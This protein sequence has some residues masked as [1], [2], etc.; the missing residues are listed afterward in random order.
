MELLQTNRLEAAKDAFYQRG[1]SIINLEHGSK[2]PVVV[3][4]TALDMLTLGVSALTAIAMAP[5]GSTPNWGVRCGLAPGCASP[6]FVLDLDTYKIKDDSQRETVEKLKALQTLLVETPTGGYHVYFQFDER[7]KTLALEKSIELFGYMDIRSTGT[8]VVGWSSVLSNAGV[9]QAYAKKGVVLKHEDYQ[10]VNSRSPMIMPD[11][12]YNMIH[13]NLPKKQVHVGHEEGMAGDADGKPT[14]YNVLRDVVMGL[15]KERSVEYDDWLTVVIS[16]VNVSM[17]NG[18]RSKGLRLCHKFSAQCPEKYDENITM[19]TYDRLAD[20][21]D[22]YYK[23]RAKI[24]TLRKMLE[25]DNKQLFDELFGV[26]AVLFHE[27]R[28]KRDMAILSRYITCEKEGARCNAKDIDIV[29]TILEMDPMKLYGKLVSDGKTLYQ[30]LAP[31]IYKPL[32]GHR[33]LCMWAHSFDRVFM[34]WFRK[35]CT[36]AI[37]KTRIEYV[38]NRINNIKFL[39]YEFSFI[40]LNVSVYREGFLEKWN[41]MPG[42]IPFM[43]GLYDVKTEALVETEEGYSPFSIFVPF[44]WQGPKTFSDEVEQQFQTF[45]GQIYPNDDVREYVLR[46]FANN[47]A[48]RPLKKFFMHYGRRGD[49]GKSTMF[50]LL[51]NTVGRLYRS[52]KPEFLY[53]NLFATA[54]GH[55][56]QMVDLIGGR[57]AAVA[58]VKGDGKRTI[59]NA[60]LKMLTGGDVMK[61]RSAYSAED[62]EFTFLGGLHAFMNSL[63]SV[64]EFDGGTS[65]RCVVIPY[66]SL[67]T[68]TPKGPN[69]YPRLENMHQILEDIKPVLLRELVLRSSKPLPP[70]PLHVHAATKGYLDEEFPLADLLEQIVESDAHDAFISITVLLDMY[71]ASGGKGAKD[72][73][74]SKFQT[75][76][77]SK[78]GPM[79]DVF[80]YTD[81][82]KKKKVR[83]VWVGWALREIDGNTSE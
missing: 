32:N 83:S 9:M 34:P 10:L 43:N 51:H 60:L 11:W 53:T 1:L 15:K 56:N 48:G 30:R 12:V 31:N 54:S 37:S 73:R 27:E 42:V 41:T 38:N 26:D 70:M 44:E 45:M 82:N 21:Y 36:D 75:L 68:N 4:W 22:S 25:K 74:R 23:E 69:E 62:I 64:D 77:E 35:N 40:L 24:G 39:Q 8:Q 3:G 33:E 18:Y 55:N 58:E 52:V 50:T 47:L 20:G 61:G 72:M 28:I 63:P 46:A 16:I 29:S 14:D 5:A 79:T 81:A 57:F 7:M 67:F 65:N 6:V 76:V 80:N 66:N 71:K 59:D 17:Q 19:K 78:L 13:T 2:K 49:N